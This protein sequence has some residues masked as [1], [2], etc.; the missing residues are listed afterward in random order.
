M[1]TR[2]S[3]EE[4]A[5]R[6]IEAAIKLVM[7]GILVVWSYQLIKPFLV[8]VLWGIIGLFVGATVFAIMY[9]LV[10]TWIDE[11]DE[12]VDSQT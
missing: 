7:V 9:S 1:E 12:A 11:N 6:V 4:F 10:M 8:P 3:R 5:S 2:E